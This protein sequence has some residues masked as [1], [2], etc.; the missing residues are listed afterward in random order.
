M[1]Y[2]IK[3][4]NYHSISK[5]NNFVL[6]IITVNSLKYG[7]R[8]VIPVIRSIAELNICIGI[9]CIYSNII[10]CTHNIGTFESTINKHYFA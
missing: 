10:T 9:Q 4:I 3:F 1:T 7:H 2:N 6:T 8:R 5:Y